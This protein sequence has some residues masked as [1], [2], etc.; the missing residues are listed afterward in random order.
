MDLSVIKSQQFRIQPLRNF[1]VPAIP[2]M[3][4]NTAS[5]VVV[6]DVAVRITNMPMSIKRTFHMRWDSVTIHEYV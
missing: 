1:P 2:L 4:A 6:Q 5:A 3:N